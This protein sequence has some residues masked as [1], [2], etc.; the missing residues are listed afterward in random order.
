MHTE[1]AELPGRSPRV[2]HLKRRSGA[3]ECGSER[4]TLVNALIGANTE[5]ELDEQY[6]KIRLISEMP[7]GPDIV[8]D[9]SSLRIGAPIWRYLA[10][11]TDFVVACL[12]VYRVHVNQGAID[13]GFLLDTTLEQMANGV[14][15]ITIHPTATLQLIETARRRLVPCTSRGGGMV[16]RD[17]LHRSGRSGNVWLDILPEIVDCARQNRVVLSLGATFRAANIVD[18]LDDVQRAEIRSQLEIADYI[19]QRGVDVVIEGPGHSRPSDI[20]RFA[21]LVKSSGY[22]VMPLGPVPT[23]TASGQDHIAGAIGATIMGL[24]GAADIIAAVTR[25][26]HTG[27]IPSAHSTIEA[28]AA[29]RVAAHII[30][31]HKLEDV[32]LDVSIARNRSQNRSCL[33]GQGG[34]CSRCGRS[35]P[36]WPV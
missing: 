25:E 21:S 4:R 8:T 9:L 14:G 1:A 17:L 34:D 19:S 31:M 16:I 11:T 28:I 18:T 32:S 3:I 20:Q 23:D 35:C 24:N 6:E 15:M 22:P 30:D 10:E 12:P 26:E 36:L 13:R 33:A 5:R 29:A 2:I 7:A 27:N